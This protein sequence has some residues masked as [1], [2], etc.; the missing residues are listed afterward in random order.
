MT[1]SKTAWG[2]DGKKRT[3]QKFAQRV[4]DA[5]PTS[6][7]NEGYVV[8][9]E[10]LTMMTAVDSKDH[11]KQNCMKEL[12]KAITV[13]VPGINVLDLPKCPQA[14]NIA[15]KELGKA[16]LTARTNDKIIVD[17]PKLTRLMILGII[18]GIERRQ[19]PQVD[20]CMGFVVGLRPND[21]N[22]L[23]ER[24]N[25][26]FSCADDIQ[27]IENATAGKEGLKVTGTLKNLKP[28]KESDYNESFIPEYTTPMI[29][30]MEDYAVVESGLRFLMDDAN[31]SIPCITTKAEYLRGDP[32]GA[33]RS[34]QEWR[35]GRPSGWITTEM[36]KRLGL[37]EAI[38]NWGFQEGK[39]FTKQL[40]RGFVTSCIEQGRLEL[41]HGL[42]PYHAV[43]LALGHAPLSVNNVNYLKFD[44]RPCTPVAGVV[45]VKVCKE[46]PVDGIPYGLCLVEKSE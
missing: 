8:R 3:L 26:T 41:E 30:E 34:C 16:N 25:G 38:T 42:T 4:S 13:A 9:D 27:L 10:M 39:G 14:I 24:T 35:N 21:M 23:R 46:R 12:R 7:L 17:A 11:T 15:K 28:S 45:A 1:R 22:I 43:E 36:V 5:D 6:R 2:A 33:E 44:C 18:D 31:A 32:S 20:F 29:C 19:V 40:G 37:D